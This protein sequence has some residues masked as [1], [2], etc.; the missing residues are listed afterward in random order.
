M[1][2]YIAGALTMGY[3]IAALHFLKF[4]RQTGDRLFG[5]FAIAFFIFAFQRVALALS[6][7]SGA[8][9][10]WPYGLRLLGFVL[11]IVA[12]IDKNRA[13]RPA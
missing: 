4:Q 7:M 5:L 3:A 1:H 9:P 6:V 8:S 2:F 13:R 11:I 12:I 10:L